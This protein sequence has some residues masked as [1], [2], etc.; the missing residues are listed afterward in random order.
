MDQK[1]LSD[2][3]KAIMV[4]PSETGKKGYLRKFM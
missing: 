3:G 4:D 2:R 1:N